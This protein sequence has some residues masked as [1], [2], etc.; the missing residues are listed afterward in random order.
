MTAID[1][2]LPLMLTRDSI[3]SERN[4]PTSGL[5]SKPKEALRRDWAN[6]SHF[7]QRSGVRL[8]FGAYTEADFD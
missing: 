1:T 4:P 3:L 2:D 5:P 8:P 6:C 7:G